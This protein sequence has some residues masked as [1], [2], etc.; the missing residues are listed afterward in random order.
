MAEMA[1]LLSIAISTSQVVGLL[2]H[3]MTYAEVS[4]IKW[5]AVVHEPMAVTLLEGSSLSGTKWSSN[6]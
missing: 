6:P 4:A 1:E 5:R 3:L 2:L